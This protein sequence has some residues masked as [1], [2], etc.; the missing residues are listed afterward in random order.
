MAMSRRQFE[1]LVD[2]ALEDLPPW[3]ID[4]VDNLHVLVQNRPTKDQDPEG[5]GLLGLYEG[6]SL[7]DRGVDYSGFMPDRITVFMEPH[8]ELGLNRDDLRDEIRATVI[9][10]MAHHLGISD[11]RLHELGWD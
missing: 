7:L 9:H 8:L 4:A 3:V 10:E 1:Q 2:E 6:V 5:E 11:D